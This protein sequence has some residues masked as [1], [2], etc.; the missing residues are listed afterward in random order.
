M[1]T[2]IRRRGRR[3]RVR[4]TLLECTVH[5]VRLKR[6]EVQCGWHFTPCCDIPHC[7]LGLGNTN[8]P[9]LLRPPL[10]TRLSSPASLRPPL[11]VRLSQSLTSSLLRSCY[12]TEN[13][14]Y[15]CISITEQ[16]Q[17]E[18]S[19]S[20]PV[21]FT[22]SIVEHPAT[23][24]R[25]ILP[26]MSVA[27]SCGREFKTDGDLKQHYEAKNH[28]FGCICG[29]NFANPD[30]RQQHA[31]AKRCYPV[32][33]LCGKVFKETKAL[34]NHAD[35]MSHHAMC[36]CGV[37]F[38]NMKKLRR[39]QQENL[40]HKKFVT[41]EDL[42]PCQQNQTTTPTWK[43]ANTPAPQAKAPTKQ[44]AAPTKPKAHKNPLPATQQQAAT[45]P[46]AA[47]V[48]PES[49]TMPCSMCKRSF[50]G[51]LAMMAH[52]SAKHARV[53]M[54]RATAQAIVISVLDCL[55]ESAVIALEAAAAT[56]EQIGGIIWQ[57]STVAK[58]MEGVD[59]TSEQIGNDSSE[60]SALTTDIHS[61][62]SG[63]RLFLDEIV[64][65]T[66]ADLGELIHDNHIVPRCRT[67]D[68]SYA[69]WWGDDS[70]DDGGVDAACS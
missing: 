64:S 62:P 56:T 15:S 16:A 6:G 48:K 47:A 31:V 12:I 23:S 43:S 10:F 68:E 58:A 66:E 27:C 40:A 65:E 1:F 61:S 44:A 50:P 49:A 32:T 54:S 46:T 60:A 22:S 19:V 51:P 21:L 20:V 13:A 17:I 4:K 11:F 45:P 53:N 5:E 57:K 30:H 59:H 3:D 67:A 38:A 33:C 34:H 14:W 18:I 52:I 41:L 55:P 7:W 39:H 37:M 70:E 29:K 69:F 36:A 26:N 35:S 28:R 25:C 24:L 2:S 63:C 42:A 8:F 9:P